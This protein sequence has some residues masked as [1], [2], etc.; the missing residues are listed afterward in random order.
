MGEAA[1]VGQRAG[2]GEEHQI[3]PGHE[4]VWQA[5]RVSRDGDIMGHR[6]H[7]N[8]GQ[9]LDAD[10][11]IRAKLFAPG[12]KIAQKRVADDGAL[13]ELDAMPLVIIKSDGFDMIIA[14]ERIGETGRRILTAGEQGQRP[15][16]GGP[17]RLD[18]PRF[19]RGSRRGSF[20]VPAAQPSS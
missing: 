14:L 15:A 5:A 8:F 11:V 9:R 3:A 6:R 16:R 1:P 7:G 12:R 19:P 18:E 2:E 10:E 20:G 4:S 17:G 13:I